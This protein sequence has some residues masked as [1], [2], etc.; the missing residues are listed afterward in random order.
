MI[1]KW[2]DGDDEPRRETSYDDRLITTC[3]IYNVR[4]LSMQ[5]TLKY[6]DDFYHIPNT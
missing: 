4:N 3:M 5:G 2:C 6:K 1:V